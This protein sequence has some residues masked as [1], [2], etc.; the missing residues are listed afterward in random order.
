[1]WRIPAVTQVSKIKKILRPRLFLIVIP[2]VLVA[3]G[4]SYYL[5]S[6]F[7]MK[8]FGEVVPH[9]VYRSAQ[10][11]PDNIRNWHTEYGIRTIINLR[12]VSSLDFYAQ[13][14]EIAEKLGLNHFD[15]KCSATDLPSALSL[16]ELVHILET[17]EKPILIHCR[18]GADR[19]GVASVIAAMALG[20]QSLQQAM[21][22]HLTWRY[23]HFD[24]RSTSI[25]G[26]LEDYERYCADHAKPPDDWA[27]LRQWIMDAYHPFYYR[28]SID[29]PNQISAKAGSKLPIDVQITNT[30]NMAIP[31]DNT[32]STFALAAFRGT[33]VRDTPGPSMGKIVRLQGQPFQPGSTRKVRFVLK[34]PDKPGEYKIRF[35]LVESRVTWFARQGSPMGQCHLTAH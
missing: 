24:N 23:W 8:N 20:N 9:A 2:I 11:D 16:R 7:V 25:G 5:C 35:D 31:L 14:K 26:V 12:G 33:S 19:T 29:V 21:D 13:E 27:T 18:A 22:G 15:I 28:V 3:V 30:S 34:I 6:M 1:M 4:L 17:A 32:D 10:P